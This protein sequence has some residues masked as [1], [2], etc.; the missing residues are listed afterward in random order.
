LP[1]IRFENE[2]CSV[3]VPEEVLPADLGI[4]CCYLDAEDAEDDEER[5]ADKDDV[6]DWTK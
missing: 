2:N 6:A 3:S 5:A 4:E 1:S